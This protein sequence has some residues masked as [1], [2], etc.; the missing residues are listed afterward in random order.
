MS[1]HFL[2]RRVDG[3][4]RLC[5][6]SHKASPNGVEKMSKTSKG[7]SPL[8]A[9]L[10]YRFKDPSLLLAA[11]QHPSAEGPTKDELSGDRLAFLGDAVWNL[12]ISRHLFLRLKKAPS[13]RLSALKAHLASATFLTEI[14]KALRLPEYLRLGKGEEKAG[15]REKPSILSEAVEALWAALYLDGG[16]DPAWRIARQYVEAALSHEAQALS[17]PKSAL[18]ALVQATF[19]ALPTY[20]VVRKEGAPH[21]PSYEIEVLIEGKIYGRGRGKSKKEAEQAAAQEALAVLNTL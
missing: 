12:L 3:C 1:S 8:E 17:P 13:G 20:R 9:A 4:E 2:R 14:A 16:L 7:P 15:G 21:K 10:G 6:L 5:Y 19:K 11:L 18:Q